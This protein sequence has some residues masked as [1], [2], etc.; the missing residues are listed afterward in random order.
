LGSSSKPSPRKRLLNKGTGTATNGGSTGGQVQGIA[1]PLPFFGNLKP[2]AV[3]TSF[4]S[5]N[6]GKT[7]KGSKALFD[8]SEKS[9]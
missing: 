9:P 1:K 3:K 2:M 4:T 7:E 6:I 8:G 5:V